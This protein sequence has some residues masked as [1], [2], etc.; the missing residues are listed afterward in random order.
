MRRVLR[1]SLLGCVLWLSVVVIFYK[2]CIKIFEKCSG[3]LSGV[4]SVCFRWGACLSCLWLLCLLLNC[5]S[6]FCYVW[7]PLWSLSPCLWSMQCWVEIILGIRT[8]G[9]FA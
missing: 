7:F 2:G 9:C 4:C 8:V 6:A 3:V 1:L 5:Q